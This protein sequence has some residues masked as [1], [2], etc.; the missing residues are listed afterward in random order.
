MEFCPAW[1]I[2]TRLVWG[3]VESCCEESGPVS[4]GEAP[5]KESFLRALLMERPAAS[6][7]L[8]SN[9]LLW[10]V[11]LLASESCDFWCSLP[12][13]NP[14]HLTQ[15]LASSTGNSALSLIILG[16]TISSPTY[17]LGFHFALPFLL[18]EAPAHSHA[19]FISSPQGSHVVPERQG[20]G[21]LFPFAQT[22]ESME[23]TE[24]KVCK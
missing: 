1:F 22:W 6:Q 7:P 18:G 9:D 14:G 11:F 5:H 24:L 17:L 3:L 13:S 21:S 10:G 19:A 8:S 20:Q 15:L 23:L 16:Q 4:T 2:S 12:F